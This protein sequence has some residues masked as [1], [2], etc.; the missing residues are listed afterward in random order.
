MNYR[1]TVDLQETTEY[2][3][4]TWCQAKVNA[5][6]YNSL[7]AMLFPHGPESTELR[8]YFHSYKTSN[9]LMDRTNKALCRP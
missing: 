5:I 8:F 6:Y 1:A 9:R 2:L 7:T 3:E 4:N